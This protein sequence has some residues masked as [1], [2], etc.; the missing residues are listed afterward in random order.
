M[1]AHDR[2]L[3]FFNKQALNKAVIQS[4][5]IEHLPVSQIGNDCIEFNVTSQNFIDLSR[6]E[7]YLKCKVVKGENADIEYIENLAGFKDDGD[8]APVNCLHTSLFDKIDFTLQQKNISSEIPKY[9]FPFKSHIDR[10]LSTTSKDDPSILFTKDESKAINSCSNWKAVT[11][12]AD[13]SVT[14]G[15][16]GLK[17]RAKFMNKSQIFEMCG[18]LNIDFC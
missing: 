18:P 14:D 17:R 2:S 15:N 13:T 8:V 5:M 1:E 9:A 4:Q 11:G 16:A 12:N 3:N 10:L 7:L 6:S